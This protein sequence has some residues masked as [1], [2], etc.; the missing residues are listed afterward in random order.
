MSLNTPRVDDRL[1]NEGGPSARFRSRLGRA[2]VSVVAALGTFLLAVGLL[3]A[4]FL[5]VDGVDYRYWPSD[6][7]FTDAQTAHEV[8][9]EAGQAF[10]LWK[11]DSFDTPECKVT[12][13]PS[14]NDVA[15]RNVE[16]EAWVRG[17]GAVPFV[18]FAEGRSDSNRISVSCAPLPP[19]PYSSDKPAHYYVD[20]A[21]GPALLDGF[22]PLWPAPIALVGGGFVLLL[23]AVGM[24][25]LRGRSTATS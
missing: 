19:S 1:P 11:Y 20:A 8:R 24:R 4:A 25:M 2:R 5:W 23:A 12:E 14:G 7:Q 13:L 21:D 6:A 10:L 17:A 9:V 16:A 18:A 22:G 15:L 3:F